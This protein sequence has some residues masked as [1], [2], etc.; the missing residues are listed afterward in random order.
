VHIG[1]ADNAVVAQVEVGHFT[2]S[3]GDT[4]FRH[5]LV[6]EQSNSTH[7]FKEAVEIVYAFIGGDEGWG[8]KKQPQLKTR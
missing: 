7:I 2:P 3:F 1:W 6:Q 8:A 4:I 5:A